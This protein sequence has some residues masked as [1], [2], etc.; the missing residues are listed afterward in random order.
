MNDL[1]VRGA[2]VS[3]S[4]RRMQNGLTSAGWRFSEKKAS[5]FEWSQINSVALGG[6]F[7]RVADQSLKPWRPARWASRRSICPEDF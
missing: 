1:S 3:G 2:L 7:D 4:T 6:G 5:S